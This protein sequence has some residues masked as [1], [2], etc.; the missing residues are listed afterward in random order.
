MQNLLKFA[1]DNAFETQMYFRV[2]TLYQD[3]QYEVQWRA[4]SQLKWRL[5]PVGEDHWVEVRTTDLLEVLNVA[6]LDLSHFE[7]SLRAHLLQ[8]AA[9][10]ESFLDSSRLLFGEDTVA[11]AITANK[12]FLA[13]LKRTVDHFLRFDQNQEFGDKP[14]K[15][16]P[17]VPFL[18][19]LK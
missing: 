6:K 4:D 3:K 15:T 8:C 13:E 9:Y 5:R 2:P 18:N 1:D 11:E 17:A 10:A 14:V 7:V 16:I 12:D 19:L